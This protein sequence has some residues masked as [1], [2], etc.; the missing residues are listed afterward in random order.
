MAERCE[1]LGVEIC[2]VIFYLWQCFAKTFRF[3][4][5]DPAGPPKSIERSPQQIC[6][7]NNSKYFQNETDS[8]III[9]I[10]FTICFVILIPTDI[11]TR[12]QLH[13]YNFLELFRV[14]P[15][16]IHL[17]NKQVVCL[18]QQRIIIASRWQ[19]KYSAEN[20]QNQLGKMIITLYPYMDSIPS[21]SCN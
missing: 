3:L 4:M 6:S 17:G 19:M 8:Q 2:F 11:Q 18:A 7:R 15:S 21:Y 16:I 10:I 12:L 13:T 9:C 1:S 5:T 20:Q 14:C